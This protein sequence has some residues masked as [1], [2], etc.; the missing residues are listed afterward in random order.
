MELIIITGFLGSGKTTTILSVAD[1]VIKRTGKRIAVIKNDFGKVGIDAKVLKRGGLT[2]QEMPSGCICCTLEADFLETLT[3]VVNTITPDIVLVEPSGIA[4]PKNIIAAM[5]EYAGPPFRRTRTMTILDI[6]R[7]RKVLGSF[8]GPIGDQI[9][10]ADIVLVN[11]IDEVDR[12]Q[13][14]DALAFLE[15][16]GIDVPVIPTSV[17]KGTNL[18][19]VVEELVR[20]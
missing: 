11:K 13:V 12:E 20:A 16:R 6:V 1:Q 17:L 9:D 2:V 18:D 4:N 15:R 3:E 5:G 19:R 7:F 14:D 8:P 10:V